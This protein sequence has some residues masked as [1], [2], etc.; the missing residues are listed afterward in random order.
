MRCT[1]WVH[2]REG[3]TA[4]VFEVEGDRVRCS[5]C[6]AVLEVFRGQWR[7]QTE[8]T[9]MMS[10]VVVVHLREHEQKYGGVWG[11]MADATSAIH[12]NFFDH[13]RFRFV[14]TAH[15]ENLGLDILTT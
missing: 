14:P 11:W 1:N 13:N 9:M 7:R 15:R 12:L 6:R 5:G 2:E 4:D 8:H 3:T 10:L